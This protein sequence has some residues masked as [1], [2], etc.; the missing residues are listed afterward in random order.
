MFSLYYIVPIPLR[1]FPQLPDIPYIMNLEK[2]CF[3]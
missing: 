3:V 2:L 1:F